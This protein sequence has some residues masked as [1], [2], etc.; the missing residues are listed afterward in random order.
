VQRIRNALGR[1]EGV[2]PSDALKWCSVH[3]R[4][5]L[6]ELPARHLPATWGARGTPEVVLEAVAAS[7]NFIR[8]SGRS[9]PSPIGTPSPARGG[10]CECP[11]AQAGSDGFS[12]R[13]GRAAGAWSSRG[14]LP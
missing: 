5:A 1:R 7:Y 14:L 12:P 10:A 4:G 2:V 13:L 8:T 3:S 6:R 9:Q 11:A